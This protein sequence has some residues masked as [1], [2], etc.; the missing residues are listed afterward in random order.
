MENGVEGVYIPEVYDEYC[1][2]R[3]LVTEWIDGCKLSDCPPEEIRE[4]IAVGQECFLTQLLQVFT[5]SKV[6]SV[7][8]L[9][10]SSQYCSKCTRALTCENFCQ[11]GFFHSD[12]HPGNIMKMTDQ[13]KGKIALIDFG[14]V[15]SLQ[16]QD[17]DQARLNP[18]TRILNPKP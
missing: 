15:A 9:P 2:R 6:V 5:F 10:K 13:S 4:Y 18:K 14:L 8:T 7:A 17:M 12:P 3:L 1:T 16:Q 11:V